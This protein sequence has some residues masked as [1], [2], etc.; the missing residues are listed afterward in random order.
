MEGCRWVGQVGQNHPQDSWVCNQLT[1]PPVITTMK[2]KRPKRR[3]FAT[4]SRCMTS[5]DYAGVGLSLKVA[6]DVDLYL[7]PSD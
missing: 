2:S 6:F 1:F 5:A 3:M 4:P 7:I